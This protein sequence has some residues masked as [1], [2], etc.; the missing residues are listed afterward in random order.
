VAR[1]PADQP[2]SQPAGQQRDELHLVTT[3]SRETS[4]A[5]GPAAKA[6]PNRLSSSDLHLTLIVTRH[7]T[8]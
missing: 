7:P 1:P 8:R 6:A 5:T 2:T 4:T 3:P